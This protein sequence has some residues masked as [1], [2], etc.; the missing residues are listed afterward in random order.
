M[1]KYFPKKNLFFKLRYY[2]YLKKDKI[3]IFKFFLCIFLNFDTNNTNNLS[4]F[5]HY[6]IKLNSSKFGAK[7]FSFNY[8]SILSREIVI[9]I[10]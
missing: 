2:D 3:I 10:K 4:K 5:I 1:K 9:I 8:N 6:L 7:T